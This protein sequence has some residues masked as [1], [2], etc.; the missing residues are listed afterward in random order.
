MEFKIIGLR[1]GHSLNCQGAVGI[2]NEYLEM[3]QLYKYVR[4]ILVSNGHTVINCNSNANNESAE[5]REGT[6]KAN[7]NNVDLYLTLHM[8]SYNGSAYGVEAWVYSTNSKSYAVAKRLT[9][10]YGKLGFYNRGVKTSTGLHDLR[11]SVA[12]AI[13]FET[14]F[15]DSRKDIE[16]W[17]STSWKQLARQICNAI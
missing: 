14:C 4:D 16:I 9:E 5:L 3:Q 7:N 8:N 15:C 6:Y 10:N 2:T 12:P 13:I 1:G 17:K 11:R